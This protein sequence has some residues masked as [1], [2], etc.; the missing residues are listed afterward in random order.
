LCAP[1]CRETSKVN[2]GCVKFSLPEVESD[3]RRIEIARP[4]F[5]GKIPRRV[6]FVKVRPQQR[7]RRGD[8]LPELRNLRRGDA[9][10]LHG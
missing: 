10:R 1:R 7:G 6:G 9:Y 8:A 2:K 3:R 5:A 4:I